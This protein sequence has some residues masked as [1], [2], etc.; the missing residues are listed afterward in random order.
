[1]SEI[2]CSVIGVAL[3]GLKDMH[4]RTATVYGH[5][6]ALVQ[7]GHT[8]RWFDW[9]DVPS[10]GNILVWPGFQAPGGR[11]IQTTKR[12]L[13]L[14]ERKDVRLVLLTA[15]TTN[16]REWWRPAVELGVAENVG[17]CTNF[18]R[19]TAVW[20]A[21]YAFHEFSPWQ[22]TEMIHQ[23]LVTTP[24]CELGYV[25]RPKPERWPT[26]ETLDLDLTMIGIGAD[27]QSKWPCFYC[28]GCKF[29][30]LAELYSH[31]AFHYHVTDPE[32]V[33]CQGAPT[34][35]WEAWW[36]GRPVIIHPNV[37]LSRPD[38]DWWP[39]RKFV[40]ANRDQI[41]DIIQPIRQGRSLDDLDFINDLAIIAREQREAIFSQYYRATPQID[42]IHA[43]FS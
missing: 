27:K 21:P 9:R 17:L 34:R 1:M 14:A 43:F 18:L 16:L 10:S 41:H 3:K 30:Y 8:I 19:P 40:A 31:A 13:S 5:A 11:A 25:G 35:M 38:V 15:D 6:Q 28:E 24:K 33:E 32:Y 42:K 4:V 29:E 23:S 2:Q 20:R 26:L 22:P 37:V 7:R 36:C 12:I 39:M